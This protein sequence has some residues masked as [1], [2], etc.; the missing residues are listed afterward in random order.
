MFSDQSYDVVLSVA[1]IHHLSESVR[2][3]QAIQ[4]M[5]RVLKPKGCMFIQVWAFEQPKDSKRKFEGDQDQLVSWKNKHERYYHLFK[6]QE[7]ETLVHDSLH[8]QDYCVRKSF[9]DYGNWG[10]IVDRK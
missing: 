9:Y 1:V 5:F 4:E 8:D 3:Q 2:R 7:L 6:Q 10:I